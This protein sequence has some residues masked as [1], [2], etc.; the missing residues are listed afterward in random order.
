MSNP[1]SEVMLLEKI[2]H[3]VD[4]DRGFG[5]VEAGLPGVRFGFGTWKSGLPF[6]AREH[7]VAIGLG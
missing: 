7:R 6:R 2:G 4:K 3:F 1:S 5:L